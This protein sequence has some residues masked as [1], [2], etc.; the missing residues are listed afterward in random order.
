MKWVAIVAIGVLIVGGYYLVVW[1]IFAVV[2]KF[3][4]KYFSSFVKGYIISMTSCLIL[5][6]IAYITFPDPDNLV[7]PFL[8]F[9][10]TLGYSY[11]YFA[12]QQFSYSM[13]NKPLIGQPQWVMNFKKEI[14]DMRL[15]KRLE[16]LGFETFFVSAT[17]AVILTGIS[18]FVVM[19]VRL[20]GIKLPGVT[21]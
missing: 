1:P 21:P 2:I 4:K 9:V 15:S 16:Y 8:I 7:M 18:S 17:V 5:V 19:I 10:G 3:I 20:L 11:A 14:G 13:F 6:G 12:V